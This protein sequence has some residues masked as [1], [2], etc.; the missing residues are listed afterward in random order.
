[1]RVPDPSPVLDKNRARMGP[2][3]ISSTGAGI[4]RKAPKAFPD[5]NSV[6]DKFQSA[7]F[8]AIA[9]YRCYTP[10]SFRKDGLSQAKDWPWREGIA[11]KACL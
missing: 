3:I 11:E 7:I 9:D 4:W 10:I 8:C 2:E 5:S 1:M 6:L